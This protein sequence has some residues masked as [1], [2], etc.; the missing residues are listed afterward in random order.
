ME[1]VIESMNEKSKSFSESVHAMD[2]VWFHIIK[3]TV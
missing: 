3:N 1:Q 2:Q